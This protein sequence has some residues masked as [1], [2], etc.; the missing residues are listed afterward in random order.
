MQL[1]VNRHLSFIDRLLK[2][3]ETL[4]EKCEELSLKSKELEKEYLEKLERIKMEHKKSIK[5]AREAWMAAEQIKREKWT[6]KKTKAIKEITIK[7]EPFNI[8]FLS[9][10]F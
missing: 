6:L 8:S 9:P 3:K 5:K 2:D 10:S 7:W 4:S 1:A